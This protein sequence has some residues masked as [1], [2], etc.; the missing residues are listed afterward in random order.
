MT[1]DNLT[2]AVEETGVSYH[3]QVGYITIPKIVE[4]FSEKTVKKLLPAYFPGEQVDQYYFLTRT[5]C[6][7]PDKRM[8]EKGDGLAY[9]RILAI[10]T[11]RE[12][13]HILG[14]FIRQTVN[15]G[16]LPIKEKD[17]LPPAT[18]DWTMS[19]QMS[20]IQ[21]QWM[22]LA[23]IF[24]PETGLPVAKAYETFDHQPL[25]F[26]CNKGERKEG[27]FGQIDRVTIL[28]GHSKFKDYEVRSSGIMGLPFH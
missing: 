7:D 5:I 17:H 23:P 21:D 14:E 9:D 27:G 12:K 10:L 28:K 15:N 24:G 26:N 11:R 25:P 1:R 3:T 19:D 22:V 16:R 13:G 18:Y 8:T 6:G 20:F 4:I 2:R